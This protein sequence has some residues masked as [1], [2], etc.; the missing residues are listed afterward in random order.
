M[1]IGG[2]VGY[3]RQNF[4]LERSYNTVRFFC[5]FCHALNYRQL[6][7]C[8]NGSAS[9]DVPVN[10]VQMNYFVRGGV[11]GLST[12]DVLFPNLLF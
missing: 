4:V 10:C 5:C 9:Y 12:G 6:R 7:R 2:R 3:F 11:T 8:V 1:T